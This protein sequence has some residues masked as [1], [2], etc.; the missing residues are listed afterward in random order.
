MSDNADKTTVS[1]DVINKY[2]VP[3][4]TIASMLQLVREAA[5]STHNFSY[6]VETGRWDDPAAQDKAMRQAGWAYTE[7][8]KGDLERAAELLEQ[9]AKLEAAQPRITNHRFQAAHAAVEQVI[10]QNDLAR[11]YLSVPFEETKAAMGMGAKLDREKKQL[12]VPS[13]LKTEPFDKWSG[14]GRSADKARG[15][16]KAKSSERPG[17]HA[18]DPEVRRS[19][20]LNAK[21]VGMGQWQDVGGGYHA[22][23]ADD[24]QRREI[25][26]PEGYVVGQNGPDSFDIPLPLLARDAQG[27]DF[28]QRYRD[29]TAGRDVPAP[30]PAIESQAPAAA[31]DVDAPT[32]AAAPV[33]DMQTDQSDYYQALTDRLI[34]QLEK[35][36]AP[37]QKPWDERP[38]QLPYNA[39][40]GAPYRGTNSLFLSLAASINGLDDPRWVTFKQAKDLGWQVKR[41]QKGVALQ[42]WIFHKDVA[43]MENGAPV[44]DE[45]GK[46]RTQRVELDRPQRKSFTVF[47]ASQLAN[48]PELAKEPR[49]Y[50]WNPEERAEQ[51][52]RASG[53]RVLHDQADRAYYSV[54]SDEVHMPRRNQFPTPAAYYG[55]AMHEL[56]H[57]SGHES[58]LNRNLGNS[59]GSVEYAKEE[60]R[61]EL[62]SYFLGDRLGVQHDPANHAAYVKSWIQVLRDD[63]AEIFRASADAMKI[64]DYVMGLDRTIERET[65]LDR[66]AA[67]D[68]A[69]T[70]DRAALVPEVATGT[71]LRAALEAATRRVRVGG[72]EIDAADPIA[73]SVLSSVNLRALDE[74]LQR[75]GVRDLKPFTGGASSVVLDAGQTRVVRIGMGDLPQRPNVEGILQPVS[76]G[77]L[78]MLR[79]EVMPRVSTEGITQTEVDRLHA[80]LRARG[81]EW[82]DRGTDNMGFING[83]AVVIDGGL[84]LIRDNDRQVSRAVPERV[85]EPKIGD[86]G[87]LGKWHP[88]PF[89]VKGIRF[90]SVGHYMEFSKAKV[91]G[92][93][94]I[95]QQLLRTDDRDEQRA[96]GRQVAGYV[97]QTW[98]ARRENIAVV[99]ERE[100]FLQNR[101]LSAALMGASSESLNGVQVRARE[102][103][104]MIRHRAEFERP[105]SAID[106]KAIRDA[107]KGTEPV[108]GDTVLAVPYAERRKAADLGAV[109]ASKAEVWFAPAGLDASTFAKWTAN[110]DR[111]AV[112]SDLAEAARKDFG[113]AL[114]AFNLQIDGLSDGKAHPVMDG[115]IH[116]VPLDGGKRGKLDGAYVGHLD[117]IKPAGY[118]HNFVSG[119][120]V[121]WSG[122]GLSLSPEELARQTAV[123]ALEAQKRAAA[124]DVEHQDKARRLGA[125]WGYLK[126]EPETG[127]T[128]LERKQVPAI[129]VK[130]DGDKTVIPLRD[131]N[132]KIWSLQ[133][134]LPEKVQLD[135][136]GDPMDKLL[137]K[138]AKK[139]GMMHTLGEIKP[140]EPIIVMEGYAT[141]ASVHLATGYTTVMAVD[142]GN[143][144]PVVAAI[145]ERYPTNPLFI[146]ADDDRFPNKQGL[147]DNAG[148]KGAIEAS[149]KHGVG[150]LVPQFSAEG[151]LTDF[152]DLHVKE[153]LGEVK[154]QIDEGIALSVEQS[155]ARARTIMQQQ[156]GVGVEVSAAGAA[157][158][159]TGEVLG[160]TQHHVAQAVG[161][162]SGVI[163]ETR[164][165]DTVPLPGNVATVQYANGRGKVSDRTQE[166]EL[167]RTNEVER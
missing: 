29:A 155:R 146:G 125:R 17:P 71:N 20:W 72:A 15:A 52:L 27:R 115:Q 63:K 42:K 92:D 88:A 124:R 127:K 74:A 32:V 129:G 93:E 150:I 59:F 6:A 98:L 138:G 46:P 100:K 142:S 137:A 51:I 126:P 50:E 161:G 135:P 148:L 66:G 120:K 14:K 104:T 33:R 11:T 84:S 41:G 48:V 99:G 162:N 112:P 47:H 4:T 19:F 160:V 157:T 45:S 79:Y 34:E 82:S 73:Q 25:L 80:D 164:R 151:K 132:R 22:R 96:L 121:N 13:A 140:G 163:H 113:N 158:R 107:R 94:A 56:G 128:Y 30:P 44:L 12:Y 8:S 58:R 1:D 143:L 5:T 57:W 109:W 119:Q 97:D 75:D 78:G 43:M 23:E 156:L 141:A 9:C 77:Q 149:A 95:A 87:P 116:R 49:K 111:M 26:T 81:V 123:A 130:F 89:E 110:K 122:E 106:I 131:V 114:R 64:V 2:A 90:G 61:A 16:E 144:E 18:K 154:R 101:A 67:Q 21:A 54:M 108:P 147:I 68:V 53:A 103:I 31:R 62:A 145:K 37:W 3:S 36:T 28:A 35:G 105:E 165:L 136:E 24:L 118:M 65:G 55:T 133:T 167:K 117:G 102:Q 153:G 38:Q 134:L 76:S 159:H 83:R 139:V 86:T 152:N 69:A 60:L 70:V 40:T 91:F 166:K 7:V 85:S 10:V 39:L